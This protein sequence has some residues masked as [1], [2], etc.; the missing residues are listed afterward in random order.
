MITAIVMAIMTRGEKS[1][2]NIDNMKV[3]LYAFKVKDYSTILFG[4]KEI[5][6]PCKYCYTE[7]CDRKRL[8]KDKD[9]QTYTVYYVQRGDGVRYEYHEDRIEWVQFIGEFEIRGEDKK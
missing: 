2:R 9:C 8:N 4:K 7:H 3:E 1:M 6:L 5:E